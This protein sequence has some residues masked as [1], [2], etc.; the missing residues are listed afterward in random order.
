MSPMSRVFQFLL[1]TLLV[2][3][4]ALA[5]RAATCRS[6]NPDFTGLCGCLVDRTAEADFD[7]EVLDQLLGHNYISLP[8]EEVRR[9]GRIFLA[10]TQE[11]IATQMAAEVIVA[12]GSSPALRLSRPGARMTCFWPSSRKA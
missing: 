7:A 10:C 6:A 1:A 5:A 9:F 12:D 8:P 4:P 2:S 11:A 3:G